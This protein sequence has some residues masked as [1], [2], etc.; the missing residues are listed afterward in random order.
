MWDQKQSTVEEADQSAP[1][2]L[3]EVLHKQAA[4]YSHFAVILL[5]TSVQHVS[6]VRCSPVLSECLAAWRSLTVTMVV[7]AIFVVVCPLG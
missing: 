7:S 6:N 5:S 3:K 1:C 4:S 2:R